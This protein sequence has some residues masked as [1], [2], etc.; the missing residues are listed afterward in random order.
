MWKQT[1]TKKG[2]FLEP[3]MTEIDKLIYRCTNRQTQRKE[4][5]RRDKFRGLRQ[6]DK[7][8]GGRER[9]NDTNIRRDI[10]TQRNS[11]SHINRHR[12]CRHM[13]A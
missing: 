10:Y 13:Q 4:D 12:Q 2:R 6:T 3:R 5:G 9:Q 8:V 7:E 1:E 11:H